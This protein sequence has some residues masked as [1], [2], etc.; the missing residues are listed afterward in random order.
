MRAKYLLAVLSA[1]VLAAPAHSQTNFAAGS[2]AAPWVKLPSSARIAGLGEAGT[3]LRGDIEAQSLNPAAL[4]GLKGQQFSLMH[5]IYVLDSSV[6][7]LGY[8]IGLFENSAIAVSADYVSFGAVDQYKVVNNALVADG[9]IH[10]SAWTATLGLGHQIGSLALGANAKM[11]NQDLGGITGNAFAGDVGAQLSLGGEKAGADL[12]ASYQNM[13]TELNGASLPQGLKL[14]AILR[15]DFGLGVLSLLGDV[16]ALAAQGSFDSGSMA[17]ELM[18]SQT[19]ALRG[20]YKFLG[21]GGASGLSLGGGLR[22]S[23]FSVDYAYTTRDSL[24]ASN[25][26][27]VGGRF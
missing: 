16:N 25:Q 17:V 1:A 19:Y 21:N 27:S 20:G 2:T 18:G 15:A 7:H 12:G 22:F 11:L 13:G 4:A 9:S 6:Q 24:G 23:G 10:P 26:I 5:N 14:G 3:A 8:G